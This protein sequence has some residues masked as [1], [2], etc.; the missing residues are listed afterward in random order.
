MMRQAS[1][2]SGVKWYACHVLV[3]PTAIQRLYGKTTIAESA[4]ISLVVSGGKLKL[5]WHDM[6]DRT[7]LGYCRKTLSG[8][9]ED[10]KK[11][12]E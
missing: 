12:I 1:L 5:K 3:R 11:I 4:S 6:F 10:Y 8:R 7:P 9:E 2:S